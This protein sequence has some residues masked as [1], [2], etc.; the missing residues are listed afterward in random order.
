MTKKIVLLAVLT[1]AMTILMTG[2]AMAA[3]VEAGFY[4]SWYNADGSTTGSPHAGFATTSQKCGYCHA[5]HNAQR[6]PADNTE[7]LLNATADNACSA[8]HILGG[9]ATAQVYG[10]SEANYTADT[11]YNHSSAA[12]AACVGCHAVHSAGTVTTNLDANTATPNDFILK[13]ITGGQNMGTGSALD[14]L[15]TDTVD[16]NL[17]MS[18]YCTQCH[19]YYTAEYDDDA[20]EQHHVMKAAGVSYGNTA[21]A[22]NGVKIA[23]AGSEHCFT[24]HDYNDRATEGFPHWANDGAASPTATGQRFM[25]V[26]G[27]A[28]GTWLPANDTN[29]TSNEDGACLKCHVWSS[30]TGT[31]DEGVGLDF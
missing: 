26:G 2:V 13:Y 1:L 18:R 31:A 3:Y 6:D 4:A 27:Y 25:T 15:Q 30:L 11:R 23:D 24:C 20:T 8:C 9:I 17:A 5:V 12:G 14:M 19:G 10:G 22:L 28:E 29:G 21:T 16:R 7:V